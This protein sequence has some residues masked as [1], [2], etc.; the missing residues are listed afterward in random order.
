MPQN[1]IN[2]LCVKYELNIN[3]LIELLLIYGTQSGTGTGF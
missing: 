3:E 1:S 2:R